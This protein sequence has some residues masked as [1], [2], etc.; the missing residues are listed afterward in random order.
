MVRWNKAYI[1]GTDEIENIND[2]LL[3]NTEYECVACR[4]AMTPKK[5]PIRTHHFAHKEKT[6]DCDPE[7]YFHKLGK[8]IFK[9]MFDES[10][11]F[12]IHCPY[13]IDLKKENKECIIEQDHKIKHNADLLLKHI[14]NPQ[15]DIAIE[16]YV[17]HQNTIEKINKG[18]P[19]IEIKIPSNF[20]EEDNTDSDWIENKIKDICTPPL[21]EDSNI[22]FYN[23]EEN[24]TYVS[25]KINSIS[26][27]HSNTLS[28]Y[29]DENDF[30]IKKNHFREYEKSGESSPFSH[31]KS[32]NDTSSFKNEQQPVTYNPI[33]LPIRYSKEKKF[34]VDSYIAEKYP[35]IK[36]TSALLPNG[37]YI[38]DIIVSDGN[39]SYKLGIHYNKYEVIKGDFN[40]KIPDKWKQALR[41]Y[42]MALKEAPIIY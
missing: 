34:I 39:E 36:H 20:I 38:I 33:S 16:I 41:E 2:N 1:K 18:Y 9:Q 28:E 37:V 12:E 23:F 22:R 26:D 42:I 30:Y 10:S 4:K 40:R 32:L 25:K 27:I 21:K 31:Q 11:I 3:P 19:I 6:Q 14:D 17:S 7:S 5:G 24:I 8:T 29:C 13:C 15:K 35:D